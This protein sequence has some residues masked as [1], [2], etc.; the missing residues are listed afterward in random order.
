MNDIEE[1]IR[2]KRSRFAQPGE[3]ELRK[4]PFKTAELY[5]RVSSPG[6]VRDSKESIGQ[7][8]DLV[9]L[10]KRDGYQTSLT[11]AEI[12]KR[13]I[14][15]Q[16]G[17]AQADTWSD[18]DVVVD[19][20]DLGISGLISGEQRTGMQ[21]LLQ[22]LESGEIGAVYV[23]EGMSRISRDRD[24]V[25][26]YQILRLMKEQNC[27][28][29]T[30]EEIRNP[31][32]ERDWH[33]LETEIVQ[34]V[35]ES[36]VHNRRLIQRKRRKA[37]R[38]DYIG[39][40]VPAGFMVPIVETAPN[41][42]YIYGKLEPY[43]PHALVTQKVLN[44]YRR[45]HGSTTKT[46]LALEGLCYPLFPSELAYMER[47]S[48]LRATLKSEHGYRITR[49][50]VRS[51]ARN[52]KLI[53]YWSWGDT[54]PIGR[55]HEPIISDELFHEVY[56]LATQRS[57]PRGRAIKYEPQEWTGLLYCCNHDIPRRMSSHAS[58]KSYRCEF[59]DDRG[60]IRTC[61]DISAKYLNEP[62]SALVLKQLDLTP[63]AE[64]IL[65]NLEVDGAATTAETTQIKREISKK[66]QRLENL[67]THLG[68]AAKEREE[69]Y[70]QLIEQAEQ[71][72]TVLRT[73]LDESSNKT[74]KLDYREVRDF[75][76]EL[77]D[78]WQSFST[79][80]R[81]DLLKSLIE[82]VEI[83]H[84]GQLIAA[85]IHWTTGLTQE[86]SIKRSRSRGISEGYWTNQE[87]ETLKAMFPTEGWDD[88][89]NAL[90]GRTVK[91]ISH[92]ANKMKLKRLSGHKHRARSRPWTPEEENTIRTLYE[93]G[94]PV[95]YIAEQA[96]RRQSAI[97]QHAA[98]NSWLR[99]GHPGTKT[100]VPYWR[101][102]VNPKVFKEASLGRG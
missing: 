52:E 78:R 32:I 56:G 63:F 16:K 97:H 44:E 38:G 51:L 30:P 80:I 54:G 50:M 100:D 93:E 81:N 7:I 69:T 88:I 59:D 61:F 20:R 53:G 87:T 29:R 27:R 19:V 11:G 84:V 55:N 47:L 22:R 79:A 42:R 74:Q 77:P 12:E 37:A 10:A 91:S 31:R 34:A 66:E 89:L 35:G 13:L 39:E 3:D 41:G 36:A 18:G 58:K 71:E 94:V 49:A 67:K 4:L 76:K 102:V 101:E 48:S 86:V 96:L 25:E 99:K 24:K 73:R 6:Q 21:H 5:G 60:I 15:I 9:E 75:L 57:K 82:K 62:L 8:A 1:I 17:E 14:A 98:R 72:L 65:M 2:N 90:P 68:N 40:P 46:L 26:P 85:K 33:S 92:K 43:E 64:E 45:Q 28:V 70:W 95:S 23:T 83:R